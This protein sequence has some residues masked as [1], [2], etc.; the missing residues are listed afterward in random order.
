MPDVIG[1]GHKS[2]P[3]DPHWTPPR[4][5]EDD[6]TIALFSPVAPESVSVGRPLADAVTR[7]FAR[8]SRRSRPLPGIVLLDV[9]VARLLP[10]RAAKPSQPAPELK[11]DMLLLD[12]LY[13]IIIPIANKI[14]D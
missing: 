4:P 3:Q 7:A 8:A 11:R 5:S 10:L 6:A 9:T 2:R 12:S 14:F 13:T 1:Y